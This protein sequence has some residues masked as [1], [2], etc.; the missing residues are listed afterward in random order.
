MAT[1]ILVLAEKG[2]V[3]KTTIYDEI[4]FS[5]ERTQTP[6]ACYDLDG[7]G[8]ATH[9]TTTDH[10]ADVAVI[11]T[12]G[13]VTGDWPRLIGMADLVVIPLRPS[14]RDLAS[15]DRTLSTVHAKARPDTKVLV[16][17]NGFNRYQMAT[18]MLEHLRRL[19]TGFYDA[20]VT[21]PQSEAIGKAA[22]YGRSVASVGPR[23]P[24][25]QG[26]AR[27]MDVVRDLAGLPAEHDDSHS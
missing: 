20:L 2:G 7:Q 26:M 14:G 1:T 4:C 8:G 23:T 11:D 25:A 19:Q 5:L 17:L 18:Q 6:Y 10:D 21:L 9:P 27:L 12:P 24:G 15:F 22:T 13:V 3:G 16:V